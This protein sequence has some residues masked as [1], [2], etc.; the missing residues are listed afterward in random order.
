MCKMNE[1]YKLENMEIIVNDNTVLFSRVEPKTIHKL[2]PK[3]HKMSHEIS[4][5]RIHV[6]FESPLYF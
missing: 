3:N 2:K 1:E 5:I 6:F 4:L